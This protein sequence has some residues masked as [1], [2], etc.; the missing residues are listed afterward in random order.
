MTSNIFLASFQ[1]VLDGCWSW[2]WW[3]FHLYI[4][5]PGADPFEDYMPDW[6]VQNMDI[7]S[8][9]SYEILHLILSKRL[10]TE[11]IVT[12]VIFKVH[13]LNIIWNV[14]QTIPQRMG[15]VPIW[16][17]III[18]IS[19]PYQVIQKSIHLHNVSVELRLLRTIPILHFGSIVEV[20]ARYGDGY[21]LY[22]KY[23]NRPVITEVKT[24][25]DCLIHCLSEYERVLY[26]YDIVRKY[27]VF[28]SRLTPYCLLFSHIVSNNTIA[29]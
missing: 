26:Y 16:D 18:H 29:P 17:C 3:I 27:W 7:Y 20:P 8:P 24:G 14:E 6:K 2:R 19:T 1:S 11:W 5:D 22:S 10:S 4:Y 25:S 28:F 15:N 12:Y 23:Q 13:G 21:I 9:I